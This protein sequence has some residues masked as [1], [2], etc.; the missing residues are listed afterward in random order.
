MDAGTYAEVECIDAV[1]D[2][3]G[4]ATV[5]VSVAGSYYIKLAHRN[6]L[7]TWSAMPISIS[8]PTAYDFSSSATQ[9]YGANMVEVES[10]VWALWSGDVNQD[11]LIEATDYSSIENGVVNFTFGYFATDLTGDAL[12]EASDYS[13][14]E[15]NV[16]LFLFSAHP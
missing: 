1:L 6:A 7:Q 4:Q 3:N 8:G 5:N 14:V 12:V 2:I 15:N 9:A 13:L 10:G 11:E 16:Q